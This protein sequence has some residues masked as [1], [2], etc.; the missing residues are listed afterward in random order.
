MTIETEPKMTPEQ[1]KNPEVA[2]RINR[3]ARANL[4]SPYA[5]L[6]ITVLNGEV[7]A[8]GKDLDEMTANLK[9]LGIDTSGSIFMETNIDYD[10]TCY[11][12]HF[13][14]CTAP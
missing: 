13:Y 10:R 5:N 7:I 3:E 9:A 1:A 6:C 11:I 2:L 4:D 8:Q 12:G 14:R